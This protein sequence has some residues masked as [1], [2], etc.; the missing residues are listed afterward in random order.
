MFQIKTETGRLSATEAR[1]ASARR[2]ERRSE[3][4]AEGAG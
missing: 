4:E 1:A 2:L 3:N